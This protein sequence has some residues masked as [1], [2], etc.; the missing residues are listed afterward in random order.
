MR[1]VSQ[2]AVDLPPHESLYKDTSL[3]NKHQMGYQNRPPPPGEATCR[4]LRDNDYSYVKEMWPA[5][6]TP[7]NGHDPRIESIYQVQ[8]IR[9]SPTPGVSAHGATSHGDPL[10][11]PYG[12]E[13]FGPNTNTYGIKLGPQNR[14]KKPSLVGET[15]GS[16]DSDEG[17]H[18]YESPDGIRDYNTMNTQLSELDNK[19]VPKHSTPPKTANVRATQRI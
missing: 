4:E 18:I 15:T 16:M 14:V 8:N 11:N 19:N 5:A 10:S 2:M 1:N 7:T 6:A 17:Q 3:Y 9:N 13:Y 12:I